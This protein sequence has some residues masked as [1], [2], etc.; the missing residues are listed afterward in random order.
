MLFQ[1]ISAKL[2][3]KIP[4]ECSLG[5]RINTMEAVDLLPCD[6]KNQE[7]SL[8]IS[9]ANKHCECQRCLGP[10]AVISSPPENYSYYAKTVPIAETGNGIHLLHIL[11]IQC[12]ATVTVT[13]I[14]LL[15]L[16]TIGQLYWWNC[17]SVTKPLF[18]VKHCGIV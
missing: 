5:A 4:V 7:T 18:K 1:E 3:I 6:S 8:S 14:L 11:I 16:M 12:Q 9:A 17:S 10:T 13:I 2:D 15:Q